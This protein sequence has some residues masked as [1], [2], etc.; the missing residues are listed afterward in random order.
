MTDPR[1]PSWE[2]FAAGFA[3]ATPEMQLFVERLVSLVASGALTEAD[4]LE[5]ANRVGYLKASGQHVE[6]VDLLPPM[7]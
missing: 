1:A 5:V 7:H 6:L 2:R 4:L 3:V